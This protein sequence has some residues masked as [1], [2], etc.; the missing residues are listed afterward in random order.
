MTQITILS[1]DNI[2]NLTFIFSIVD[3]QLF[4]IV[5]MKLIIF[6]QKLNNII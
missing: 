2:V 6:S 5:I 1:G 4:Y 3:Y